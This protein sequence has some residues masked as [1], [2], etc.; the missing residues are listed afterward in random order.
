MQFKNQFEDLPNE[1]KIRTTFIIPY[2]LR[3]GYAAY[4]PKEGTIQTVTSILLTKLLD[5]IK[6]SSIEAGD[7]YGF[8]Q[9]VADC[10]IRIGGTDSV[11]KSGSTV[12]KSPTGRK[13][14]R[15]VKAATRND[16]GGNASVA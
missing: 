13:H 16:A 5:A 10:E 3:S 14:P 4:D 9:A 1:D 12:V 7:R 6:Q 11:D 15:A 8:Q 2:K